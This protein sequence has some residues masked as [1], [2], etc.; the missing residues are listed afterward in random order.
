MT[1]KRKKPELEPYEHTAG[2]LAEVE[3]Y[4]EYV[5]AVDAGEIPA[6]EA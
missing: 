1:T 5:R 6:P 3:A 2:E 4:E